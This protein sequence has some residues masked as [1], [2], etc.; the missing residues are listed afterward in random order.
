MGIEPTS[1]SDCRS[2]VLKTAP[3]TRTDTPPPPFYQGREAVNRES[4][5]TAATTACACSSDPHTATL[6]TRSPGTCHTATDI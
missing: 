5:A 4:P 2:T 3:P 1:D 6:V